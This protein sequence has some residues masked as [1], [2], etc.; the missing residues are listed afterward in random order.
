MTDLIRVSSAPEGRQSLSR[1]ESSR[2]F[3]S[4]PSRS[5]ESE[6]A[7]ISI[8]KLHE[9]HAITANCGHFARVKLQHVHSDTNLFVT[10]SFIEGSFIYPSKSPSIS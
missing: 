4:E 8:L 9:L 1:T 3:S 10:P 5:E 7:R 6:G 2:S